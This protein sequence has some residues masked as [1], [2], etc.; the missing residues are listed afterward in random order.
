[1]RTFHCGTSQ[2]R[3]KLANQRQIGLYKLY[4]TEIEVFRHA[5][6]KSDVRIEIRSRVIS[7]YEQAQ[8]VEFS[9][10]FLHGF[11]ILFRRAVRHRCNGVP[12]SR[13]WIRFS[14]MKTRIIM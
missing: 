10:L 12:Y 14:D 5:E 6:S 3:S 11:I 1:M 8:P 7:V 9:P 13:M 4:I 2:F